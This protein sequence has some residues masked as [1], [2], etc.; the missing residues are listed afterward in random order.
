[1]TEKVAI[2]ARVSTLDKGQEVNLQLNDLRTYATARGWKQGQ[3]THCQGAYTFQGGNKA[4]ILQ[5]ARFDYGKVLSMQKV[6][7]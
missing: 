6:P 2:Y 4:P 5:Q 7:A 3:G 1:M